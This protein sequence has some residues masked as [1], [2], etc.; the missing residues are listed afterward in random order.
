MDF[1]CAATATHGG[2]ALHAADPHQSLPLASRAGS[3]PRL[4][5]RPPE[6]GISLLPDDVIG[7]VLG[8]LPL[9]DLASARQACRR[10][11]AM[12]RP[13]GWV[14]ASHAFARWSVRAGFK[15]MSAGDFQQGL[16][17]ARSLSPGVRGEA[18]ERLAGKLPCLP[19]ADW[20]QCL[21]SLVEQGAQ[22]PAPDYHRVLGAIVSARVTR[23]G[24]MDAWP[25]PAMSA[26]ELF[27]A[28]WKFAGR[29][30]GFSVAAQ[31]VM[32]AGLCQYLNA[33]NRA[34]NMS[35]SVTD[36]ALSWKRAQ[37]KG[38][39]DYGFAWR[40]WTVASLKLSS[41]KL[42]DCLGSFNMHCLPFM[43]NAYPGRKTENEIIDAAG[44]IMR[45]GLCRKKKLDM[46]LHRDGQG[47]P[48]LHHPCKADHSREIKAYVGAMKRL[49]LSTA[50][51]ASLFTAR[52]L[53]GRPLLSALLC[54]GIQTGDMAPALGL[55]DTLIDDAG[56]PEAETVR[57]LR[58]NF[59][60]KPDAEFADIDTESE[61][62]PI[63]R[64][65]PSHVKPFDGL[66][67]IDSF[68]CDWLS[69]KM[70]TYMCK[71]LASSLPD[72]AKRDVLRLD[73]PDRS[74]FLRM[75][76]ALRIYC[77]TVC[78]SSLPEAMKLELTSP[79]RTQ[80][81]PGCPLL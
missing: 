10:W 52:R 35:Q 1:S 46:L 44:A 59:Q 50:E 8:R 69:D 60:R 42:L 70:K 18:L 43:S 12:E 30:P 5:S 34:V 78:G 61:A 23:D 58:C 21:A 26:Q 71:I 33:S 68:F 64:I 14:A 79:L 41:R 19:K 15:P 40:L 48:W 45:L 28:A 3:A 76:R 6:S 7:E 2:A 24:K 62:F 47:V 38:E 80:F 13:T 16:G 72:T 20:E 22:C 27:Q 25:S 39:E 65:D 63:F 74:N 31:A 51:L 77:A 17:Q 73:F 56:L 55:M 49:G 37:L 66:S 11:H 29:L 32:L 54:H 57:L 75:S 9:D 53:S 36:I 4:H 81:D 67:A